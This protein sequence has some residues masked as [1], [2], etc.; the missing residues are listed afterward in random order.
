MAS[1]GE[2]TALDHKQSLEVVHRIPLALEELDKPVI[3][4]LN[5]PAVGAGLDMALMCDLRFAAEGTRFSEGYVKVGLIPGDGGT[6]FLPR[7]VGTA[8]ALELLWTGDFVDAQEAYRIGLVNRVVPPDQLMPVVYEFAARLANGPAAAI[9]TTKRAVYQ[10]ARM[11]LRTH[12]DLI[13]SHM[14]FIRQT[15]D[16]KEGSRAFV[17]KRAPEFKGR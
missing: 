17:E 11:D 14:G 6:Y 4:A 10:G 7:L 2:M 15:E 5:G 9:R 1:R 13:S 8:K 16:H 12:L 3:A